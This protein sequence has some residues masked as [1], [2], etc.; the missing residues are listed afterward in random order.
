MSDRPRDAAPD[1]AASDA[2]ILPRWAWWLMLP[3]TIAPL[4]ILGFIVFTERAHDPERCRFHDVARRELSAGLA[5]VEQMRSCVGDVEEHR[6]VLSR[7]GHARVLGERAFDKR[8]FT[9]ATYSWQAQVDAEG[10][11]HVVVRNSGHGEIRFREGT[12][13]EKQRDG[14]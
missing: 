3:G 12:A 2:P 14:L 9:P 4:L 1:D 5:V 8:E 10:E 11:V 7:D 6:Y 13:A